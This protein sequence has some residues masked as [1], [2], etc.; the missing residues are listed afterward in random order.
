M[1]EWFSVRKSIN[2]IN[3]SF[4]IMPKRSWS[5][6]TTTHHVENSWQL[7][8]NEKADLFQGLLRR[9]KVVT[10]ALQCNGEPCL[11]IWWPAPL[12]GHLRNRTRTRARGCTSVPSNLYP[13]AWYKSGCCAIKSVVL[14]LLPGKR[15][16]LA[17]AS[18]WSQPMCAV[19][20]YHVIGIWV[21][22][23]WRWEASSR[24]H[25]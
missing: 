13:R 14:S 10:C 9:G 6:V 11:G 2:V 18:I 8:I 1:W 22:V 15:N 21:P 20:W 3:F 17:G 23:Q 7:A 19:P 16:A 12:G 5:S 25:E 4:H 24:T